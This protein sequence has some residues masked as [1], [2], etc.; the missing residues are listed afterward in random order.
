MESTKKL[1]SQI[2]PKQIVLVHGSE[3]STEVLAEHY[4]QSGDVDKVFTP[5]PGDSV[6]LTI[7]SHIYQVILSDPLMSSLAFQPVGV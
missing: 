3:Q 5:K 2:R 6:D 7:E 4:R 1:I